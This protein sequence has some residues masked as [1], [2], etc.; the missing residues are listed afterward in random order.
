MSKIG[1]NLTFTFPGGLARVIPITAVAGNVVT[2]LSPGQHKRW[3][4][5]RGTCRLTCNATVANRQ[6]VFGVRTAAGTLIGDLGVS[7]AIVATTNKA[8]DFGELNYLS[9]GAVFGDAD[10]YI[11]LSYPIVLEQTDVFRISIV[12]GVAGD[13]YSGNISVLEVPV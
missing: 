1:N 5:L 10:W 7:A 4:I 13:A 3:I 2:N 9:A 11:G 12:A 6:I 8:M